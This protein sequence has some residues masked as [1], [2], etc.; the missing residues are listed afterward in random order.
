MIKKLLLLPLLLLFSACRHDIETSI[1]KIENKRLLF[2]GENHDNYAHHLNQ[3][4]IIQ[5]LHN[6]GVKLAIGLEMFQRPFQ[7]VLDAYIA[8]DID[9]S[10]LL[11]QSEYFLR[12][13]YDY[14]LYRPI[15]ILAKE[16]GIP[17]IALNLDRALTKKIS[18]N[19]INA[20][21]T[22][23]K[24][25]LPQSLDFSDLSYKNRLMEV[26]NDP[27][28]IKMMPKKHRSNP[29]FL[30]QAQILWDETMA[31]TTAK[32]LQNHPD[33]IMIVLAGNA[34][35]EYFSGIP[36]RVKR[37]I[38]I[39]M[40]V[41]LQDSQKQKSKADQYLYPK[42]IMIDATPK[43]GVYVS[44]DLLKV[45]SISKDSIAEKLAVKKGDTII[46]LSDIPVKTLD[47]LKIALYLSKTITLRVLREG[48]EILLK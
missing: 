29:E 4:K 47:D 5:D 43:L 48:K 20:L 13:G 39:P 11:K 24:T 19:G 6:K 38:D 44:S 7:A 30:Y 31:D 41:I 8:G 23:E 15:M 25:R 35:L 33:T 17:L 45:T 2:I 22:K 34:H 32:Y 42:P 10:A 9:E 28:H 12:W 21:S 46:T 27:E 40:S 3:K 26:F 14:K 37:R 1:P 16:H 36:N 18:K